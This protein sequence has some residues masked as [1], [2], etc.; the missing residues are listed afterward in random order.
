[1]LA[2]TVFLNYKNTTLDL[3]LEDLVGDSALG[4]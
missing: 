3:K 1:M 2:G 4:W